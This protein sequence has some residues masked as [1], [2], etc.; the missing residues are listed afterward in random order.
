[1]RTRETSYSV[2]RI[3]VVGHLRVF[4][5]HG[6]EVEIFDRVWM[7]GPRDACSQQPYRETKYALGKWASKLKHTAGVFESFEPRVVETLS[8][9]CKHPRSAVFCSVFHLCPQI[10]SGRYACVGCMRAAREFLAIVV[11]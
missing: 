10:N 3:V 2:L 7:N 6:L 5:L 9:N 11:P 8:C 1:M 4:I